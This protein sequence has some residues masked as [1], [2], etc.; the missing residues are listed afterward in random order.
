MTIPLC[1][2]PL[3]EPGITSLLMTTNCFWTLKATVAWLQKRPKIDRADQK[4]A[5]EKR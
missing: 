1:V 2:P 5:F 4:L 3:T